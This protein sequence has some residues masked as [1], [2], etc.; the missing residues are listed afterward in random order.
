MSGTTEPDG[1]EPGRVTADGSNPFPRRWVALVFISLAQLMVALDATIVNI[2][3]PSAQSELGFSDANRQW[4]ITAYTLAFA[5]LVLLGGRIADYVGRKRTFM[6]GL[7]GFAAA[8]AAAGAAVNFGMLTGARALQGLFAAVLAPT[9]LSLLTVTFTET[10]ER[11][12]AFA[13]FGAIAGSGAAVG[14]LLGGVLA[15]YLS[16]RWCLYVNV[17]VSA[18]A[19]CG[20]WLVLPG[21]R[22]AARQH[23][24]VPGAL[25][26]AGGLVALVFACTEAI[27]QGWSSGLVIGLLVAAAVLLAL[28]VLL[29]SRVEHPLL[30]LRIVRDRN[31]GGSYLS[32]ALALAGMLGLF[33]FL[34]YYFQVVQHYSP[35]KTGLA[36]LPLMAAV[37]VG[38]GG[39]AGRLLP[40][41]PPRVL[42]VPGLLTAAAA[43]A[44]LTRLDVGSGYAAHVLPAEILLGVGMGCTFVPAISTAT[45][46]VDPRDAGIASAVV[47]AA[48]QAGGSIGTALLN[49]IAASATAAYLGGL[50]HGSPP[51]AA[52]LVHGYSVAAAWG[53]GILA[54]AAVLALALINAPAPHRP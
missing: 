18:V 30:P 53:A 7:I 43:M 27:G 26:A 44:L 1:V 21:I 33:L 13:V 24:D 45:F 22:P 54:T 37:Q 25:L 2:A 35:V 49:T 20:G 48:Q 39:I 32:M 40:R 16:W 10:R 4:V 51:S 47:N 23:F 31:R 11:A 15:Q 12:K 9:V 14:L 38:A 36:F 52:A 8:S 28:F 46:G 6:V 5:G 42:V 34:T 19:A 50:P 3:L 29:Q 17:P 41:V